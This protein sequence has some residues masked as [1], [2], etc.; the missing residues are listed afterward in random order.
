MSRLKD[1][2]SASYTSLEDGLLRS[3][4]RH[5]SASVPYL[6]LAARQDRV[7][8]DMTETCCLCLK[9]FSLWMVGVDH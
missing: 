5:I 3:M 7:G 1:M 9:G 4:R 2:I 6:L 8:F